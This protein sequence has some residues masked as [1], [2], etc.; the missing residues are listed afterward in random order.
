M[1]R[2][3]NRAAGRWSRAASEAVATRLAEITTGGVPAV[4]GLRALAAESVAAGRWR[5][6]RL[7]EAL[8]SLAD[9]LERGESLSDAL[10]KA[11]APEDFLAALEC[12]L[13]AGRPE[14]TLARYANY[15]AGLS[16]LRGDLAVAVAYP[17]LMIALTFTLLSV[18]A[19]TLVPQFRGMFTSFGSELPL[20]T[21][22][23]LGGA[24]FL[25]GNLWWISAGIAVFAAV[26]VML[27][28]SR[29]RVVSRLLRFVPVVGSIRHAA[30][31]ARSTHA[32]AF[33]VE[34]A[35]PLPEAVRLAGKA[36]DDAF[37]ADRAATAAGRIG[38]GV[39]FADAVADA[40]VFPPEAVRGC[41]WARPPEELAKSLHAIGDVH[42]TR[43]RTLTQLAI[44]FVE[45][46]T[47]VL[48]GTLLSVTVIAM[49]TPLIKLLQCLS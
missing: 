40:R 36:S 18:I 20:M 3:D 6:P 23:V 41:D 46:A 35:V 43:V 31:M 48:C 49:F 21:T 37:V 33:L 7:T 45:P 32:L 22:V 39:A 12:G 13:R 15:T 1:T 10:A 11:G 44:S 27:K 16:R 30:A 26:S 9:R 34:N 47:L 38:S 28:L 29:N 4:P 17:T 5:E 24:E 25:A 8:V 2:D 14:Q 19:V 42:E